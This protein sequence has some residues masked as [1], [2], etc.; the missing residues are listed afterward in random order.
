MKVFLFYIK[1]IYFIL[2]QHNITIV[3]VSVTVSL[4][5]TIYQPIS[6][7]ENDFDTFCRCLHY[8]N[9]PVQYSA[10]LMAAK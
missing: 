6:M 1:T 8:D 9:T 2:L 10:I 5:A 4:V 7:V 3:P